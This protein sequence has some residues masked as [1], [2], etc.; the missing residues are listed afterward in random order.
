[1]ERIEMLDV[2]VPHREITQYGIYVILD[3]TAM[4]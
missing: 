3:M 1:M 2:I 4:S